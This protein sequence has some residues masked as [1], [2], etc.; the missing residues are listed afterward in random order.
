MIL[1]GLLNMIIS[2]WI[3]VAENGVISFFFYG[4]VIFHYVYVH[5]I[6]FIHWSVDGHVG[7]FHVSVIINSAAV[8]IG[9]HVSFGIMVLSRFMPRSEIA[10]L[11]GSFIFSFLR[12]LHSVLQSGCTSLHSHQQCRGVPS[13]HPLQH[14]LFVDFLMMVILTRVSDTSL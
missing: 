12:N 9:V 7:C 11:Y 10:G 13:S 2:R 5:H 4:W 3:H 1:S 8:N 6:L 14:L